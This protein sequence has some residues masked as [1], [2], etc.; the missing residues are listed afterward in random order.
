MLP[1]PTVLTANVSGQSLYEALKSFKT[2]KIS[3]ILTLKFSFYSHKYPILCGN[4]KQHV[5]CL[6]YFSHVCPSLLLQ[7]EPTSSHPS[8]PSFSCNKPICFSSGAS[9]LN[10]RVRKQTGFGLIPNHQNQKQTTLFFQY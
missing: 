6:V 4:I 9:I 7:S 3:L 2:L 1:S 10:Q 8:S 5:Q